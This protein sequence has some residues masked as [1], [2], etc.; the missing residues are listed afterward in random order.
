VNNAHSSA[1]DLLK[2]ALRPSPECLEPDRLGQ[3]LT[4]R[5]E[6]HL[7]GCARCRTQLALFSEFADSTPSPDEGAAV[8]WVVQ[9]LRRRAGSTESSVP[10]GRARSFWT[11][12]FRHRLAIAAA[13]A[14]IAGVVFLAP[15]PEPVV[16]DPAGRTGAYRAREFKVIGP[17]GQQKVPPS[18]F[19]WEQVPDVVEYDFTLLEVDG[20]P[21]WETSV[22]GTSVAPPRSAQARMVPGK[23]LR[24]KVR[25]RN[26]AGVVVA[27][28]ATQE[29]RVIF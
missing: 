15:E 23:T 10:V 20:T 22:T 16:R 29:F 9:E 5:E 14:L 27:E 1:G 2:T 8:Q 6:T 13:I 25:A 19:E 7:E 24:W 12:L 17:V 4:E 21:L 11:G 26:A 18:T 28:T 3:P